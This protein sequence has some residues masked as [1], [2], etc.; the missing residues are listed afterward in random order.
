[1]SP[2]SARYTPASAFAEALVQVEALS[3]AFTSDSL[4]LERLA[5]HPGP[6][7]HD[8][9]DSRRRRWLQRL[10]LL[11][12]AYGE[13]T[14]AVVRLA[15]DLTRD[16]GALRPAR[17]LCRAILAGGE[18]AAESTLASELA[19]D[20]IARYTLETFRPNLIKA[21]ALWAGPS[22]RERNRFSSEVTA[23]L[24]RGRARLSALDEAFRNAEHAAWLLR[25]SERA[26]RHPVAY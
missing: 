5:L 11:D 24:D 2:E 18:P 6:S 3:R 19:Y 17:D 15:S 1:M 9:P 14:S 10:L 20:A 12:I 22:A 16:S 7:A 21:H 13:P 26:A 4:H 23:V 8:G 25:P